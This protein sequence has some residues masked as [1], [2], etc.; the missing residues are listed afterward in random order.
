VK[1]A[2]LVGICLAGAAISSCS[3]TACGCSADFGSVGTLSGGEFLLGLG[4]GGE[5]DS[6]CIQVFA[7][8]PQGADALGD[9]DTSLLV[10]DF[11]LESAPDSARVELVLPPV[12]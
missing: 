3:E 8:P 1:R 5:Q 10:L 2:L 4:L 6:V 7:H 11:R 9:S 12:E